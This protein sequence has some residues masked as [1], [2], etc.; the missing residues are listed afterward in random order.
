MEQAGK[1][2]TP[3]AYKGVLNWLNTARRKGL[4]S[5]QEQLLYTKLA[6]QRGGF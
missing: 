3:E 2:G 6:K 1:Q 5:Q 4:I